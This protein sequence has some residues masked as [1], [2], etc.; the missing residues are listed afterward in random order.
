MRVPERMRRDHL[1]KGARAA[2][3]W[4]LLPFLEAAK[5]A[6]MAEAGAAAA[7]AGWATA[8]RPRRTRAMPV[9]LAWQASLDP[10][11]QSMRSNLRVR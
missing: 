1:P 5:E 7:A 8:A 9:A 4:L 6:A 10:W 11:H 3:P 2:L